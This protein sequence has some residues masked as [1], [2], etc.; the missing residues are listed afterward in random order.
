MPEVTPEK[1]LETYRQCE[2]RM[3]SLAS[4]LEINGNQI[5][6][7]AGYYFDVVWLKN[8][9]AQKGRK[10][11]DGKGN[12]WVIAELYGSKPMAGSRGGFKASE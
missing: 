7:P 6:K 12:E 1:N 2:I 10:I 8:D 9:L 11:V 3:P 4:V 5:S